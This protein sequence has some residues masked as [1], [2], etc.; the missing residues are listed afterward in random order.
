MSRPFLRARARVSLAIVCLLALAPVARA[1]AQDS[2]PAAHK[3]APDGKKVLTLAD[4][5]GW[6]RIDAAS[7]SDDGQWMTY[8]YAPNEG[9]DTLFVRQLDG[10]KLYVVPVGSAAGRRTRAAA[11]DSAVEPAAPSSPTIRSGS[12]TIVNPPARAAGARGRGA[13]G[14]RGAAGARG[15]APRGGTTGG[16]AE[17]PQR[18]FE[19]LNLATG[20]K[21]DVPGATGF[22][23]SSGSR[24]VAIKMA[25]TPGD[26]SHRGTDL[27]LRRLADGV[28]QNIGNVAQYDFDDAGNLLAYTVDAVDR[29]GNGVYVVNTTNGEIARAR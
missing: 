7:I 28:S 16:A 14:G 22:Q 29:L 26:T 11:G 15:G 5:P 17:A 27:V 25:G 1:R 8:T 23:F 9:D 2:A 12:A 18:R 13:E 4:Y 19:L 3:R 20:D 10:N 21:Y 24:Y 6:K